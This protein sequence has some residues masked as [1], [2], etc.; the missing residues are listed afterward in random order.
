MTTSPT[1]T[2]T[3]ADAI[4][5]FLRSL[6]GKN[7]SPATIR[8]YQ[9]DLL[10]FAT[11]LLEND[12]TAKRPAAITR[13]HVEEY[14]A[15][16]ADQKVSGVSRARKLAA[17]RE[18]FRHLV[19][20]GQL[21]HS[22]AESVDTPR[23]ESRERRWLRPEEYTKLLAAAG[24]HPRD[25]AILQTFLQTG[26]RVAELCDLRLAD[27]DLAGRTLRIRGKGMIERTIDLEKKGVAA[28]KGYLAA[29][30]TSLD[31]HLFLNRYGAPLGER[32]VRK[33]LAAYC[34][35]AG[36]TRAVS[37]HSLRHTFGTYKAGR[38]VPLR[39]VQEWLGHKSLATTQVY[40]HLSRDQA[41]KQMEATSL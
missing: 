22:P 1:T 23:R 21:A 35:K 28:L 13:G 15:H 31:D 32:G 37:P 27:L 41:K 30:P 36:I 14:L 4:A 33:L 10:Q 39:Q 16:L 9:I 25:F 18:L 12:L 3:L 6:S 20:H 29:R 40:V 8:A 2:L 17:I 11:W 5:G 38:G 26:V 19:A 7:R 24:G 34:A